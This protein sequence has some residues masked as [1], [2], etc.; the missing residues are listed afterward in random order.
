VHTS[1]KIEYL[2]AIIIGSV[3][4]VHFCIYGLVCGLWLS[5]WKLFV[6]YSTYVCARKG[7]LT[8]VEK[9]T[10]GDLCSS[11]NKT[12]LTSQFSSSSESSTAAICTRIFI[13]L[14]VVCYG[15]HIFNLFNF[16]VE[17]KQAYE[18][19]LILCPLQFL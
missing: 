11:C 19:T 12:K 13:L 8:V 16:L 2:Y 6:C 17:I 15:I 1:E 14:K 5:C 7:D 18:I 9:T 10:A 4:E 3:S